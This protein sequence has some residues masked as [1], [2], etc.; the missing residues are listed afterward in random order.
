MAVEGKTL[1]TKRTSRG[2][3]FG[4]WSNPDNGYDPNGLIFEIETNGIEVS[5]HMSV[6]ELYEL[7]RVIDEVKARHPVPEPVKVTCEHCGH[8]LM[9]K[10]DETDGE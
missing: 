4:I 9:D 7:A 6:A 10:E 5:T 3:V 1:R 2:A 8:D